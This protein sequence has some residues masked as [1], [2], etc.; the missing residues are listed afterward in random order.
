MPVPR[1]TARRSL[2]ARLGPERAVPA[3]AIA[4]LIAATAIS[5]APV[6][7]PT[8]S[9]GPVGG[10]SGDGQGPRITAGGLALANGPQGAVDQ[11]TGSEDA[12]A[13]DDRN[14]AGFDERSTSESD[15]SITSGAYLEDGTILKPVAVDTT[16]SDG[17]GLMRTYKVRSGDTLTGIARKFSVSMMTVWWANNLKS[18]DDL[19]VGQTLTIPPVSGVVV[20]VSAS[21]TLETLAAK[22]RVQPSEIVDANQLDDPHLVIGQTLTI[23]GALGAGIATP[24]PTARPK[25]STSSG[26]SHGSVRPPAKYS[27]TGGPGTLAA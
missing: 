4:I 5:N 22:Y 8:G 18:K 11:G 21:D 24:A 14:V 13:I 2:I 26:S 19:H 17:K 15:S 12:N 10:T 6:F 3:V 27:G 20:T 9:N 25:A 7:G 1:T 23:P 16:V